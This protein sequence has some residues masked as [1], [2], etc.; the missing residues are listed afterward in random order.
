MG[1]KLASLMIVIS[2]LMIVGELIQEANGQTVICG[3]PAVNFAP[4]LPSLMPPNPQP[5]STV[6]CVTI[7]GGDEKCLC[8]F[9][10]SPL[11]PRYGIDKALF[12]AIFGKCGLPSCPSFD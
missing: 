8:S 6:C 7:K 12:L 2:M 3:I 11:L 1:K 10:N 9:S 5:P 4:C